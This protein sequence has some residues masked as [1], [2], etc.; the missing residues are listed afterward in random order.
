MLDSGVRYAI[1]ADGHI[2]RRVF[3]GESGEPAI[4]AGACLPNLYD[5]QTGS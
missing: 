4:A 3:D 5:K 1:S 2:L